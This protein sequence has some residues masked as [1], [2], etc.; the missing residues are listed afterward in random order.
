MPWSTTLHEPIKLKDGRW[1]RT[2]K[3]A[4]EIIIALPELRQKAP[5][6][7][8]AAELL[9]DV[10]KGKGVSS[11]NCGLWQTGQEHEPQCIWASIDFIRGRS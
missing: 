11:L 4:A 7:E 2:C 10:A 5:Y 3:E 9:M 8:H 1:I 6:W